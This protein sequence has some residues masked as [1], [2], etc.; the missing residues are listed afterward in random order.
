MAASNLKITIL[1]LV[2]F[3]IHSAL[4]AQQN[5]PILERKISIN[6]NTESPESVLH[7]IEEK[8]N[9]TFSYDPRLLQGKKIEKGNFVNV[10]IRQILHSLF[11]DR[12]RF[13]ENGKHIIIL[14]GNVNES[15]VPQY[16]LIS[17][18]VSDGISGNQ[19]AQVSIYEKKS[20]ESAVSN[21][22]GY[23]KL[24]VKKEE[25]PGK[26]QLTVNKATY[27]DT[28]VYVSQAGNSLLNISLYPLEE[29]KPSIDSLSIQ[30]SLMRVDQLAFVNLLLSKEE[31][32]NTVNVRDTIYRKFQASFLPYLGSNLRLSGNSVNDFSL[33]ALGGYSMGTKILEIGGLFN[34]ERD[35]VSYVQIAGLTNI[36]GGPV[37]GTQIGGLVNYDLKPVTGAQVSGFMNM[38]RDTVTGFQAAGFMNLNIKFLRGF[39]TAGFLNMQMADMTGCQ[40]AGFMNTATDH[41]RGAQIAGFLNVST[42]ELSGSQISGFMNYGSK[43]HG[44]QIGFLNIADS[45]G[46]V[47]IGFLSFVRQGVH[48]LEIS[49]NEIF[50]VNVSLRTGVPAL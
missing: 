45:V 40:V 31:K 32:I 36:V 33:N 30:D 49:A 34:I 47:P 43:V 9:F 15:S 13:K 29:M 39:S 8:A 17:G 4:F 21:E 19:I 27:K 2:S 24:K 11:S 7:Q 23:F 50:P 48:Q 10:S 26:L 28:I 44:A 14:K 6:I 3:F 12:L 35:S 22:Y 18:Y 5:V 1:L 46:G 42:N 41:F 37:T 38:S 16:Y 25:V 20:R